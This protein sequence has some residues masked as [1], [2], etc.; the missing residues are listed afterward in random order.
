MS[1]PTRRELWRIHAGLILAE[2]IC[3]PAFIIEINRAVGGNTLSW[4]YVF[5]WPILGAY[6]VYM[7]RRLILDARGVP[8][9]ERRPS[10]QPIDQEKL[11]EWNRYLDTVHRREGGSE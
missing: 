1:E 11:D 9:R 3:I 8:R 4:A 5:E 7:W 6:A 10:T 2:T